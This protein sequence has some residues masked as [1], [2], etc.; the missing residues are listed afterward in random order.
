M[1]TLSAS[2]QCNREIS[3]KPPPIKLK[4]NL[5]EKHKY[6][7]AMCGLVPIRTIKKTDK[8][9]NKNSHLQYCKTFIK[10]PY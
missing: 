9:N 8:N 7:Y 2:P 10:A 4:K 6:I 1:T 5:L 3:M